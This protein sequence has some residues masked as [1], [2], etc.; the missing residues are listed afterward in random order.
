MIRN[1]KFDYSA[2][3]AIVSFKVDTE[4]FTE[5]VAKETL[6]FFSWD[7]DEDGDLIDEAVKKYAMEAIRIA[8]VNNYNEIGV[9]G[10]F[11]NHEGYC[12]VDGS[13][14]IELIYISEYEF[15]DSYLDMKVVSE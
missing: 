1:Y 15:N 13:L 12:R 6:E 9:K 8:T 10:E 14:G 7:Y 5:E 11:E 4:V 3:E 2:G